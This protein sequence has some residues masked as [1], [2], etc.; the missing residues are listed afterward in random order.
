MISVVIPVRNG[1][2]TI[3]EQLGALSRQNADTAWE[4]VVADNGSDDGTL[5]VAESFG[6]VLP[7]IRVVDASAR[8]GPAAARNIGAESAVGDVF[9]FCDADDVVGP[10]WL[11]ALARATAE[12]DF[13]GGALDFQTFDRWTPGVSDAPLWGPREGIFGW[14]PYALGAN[15][16]VSRRAFERVGGFTE[17]LEAGEDLDLSWRLQLAG[18]PLH[19]EPHAVVSKRPRSTSRHQ[20]RQHFNYGIHDVALYE[21]L[22]GSGMPPRPLKVQLRVYGWLGV[23]LWRVALDGAGRTT[24]LKAASGAAGRIVGSVRHRVWYI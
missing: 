21:R 6:G 7:R 5:R 3:G 18:Y 13:V 4:V 17:E 16:A 24:W 22:R 12:H 15:M 1:A 11:A 2:E 19:Y 9:A 10:G 20:M 8:R 23:N 14:F